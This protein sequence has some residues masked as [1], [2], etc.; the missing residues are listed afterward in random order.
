MIADGLHGLGSFLGSA[1]ALFVWP[2]VG[3]MLI[4]TLLGFAVG[5]LPGLG[6]AATM[7]LMLPLTFSMEPLAAVAF[8]LAMHAT[9][10]T[11]GDVTSVLFG[12][13]G[14]ASS[15]ATVFDGYPMTRMGQAGRAIGAVLTSSLVGAWFGAFCLALAVPLVRPLVLSFGPPEVFMLA[16]VALTTVAALSGKNM[17]KG[18]AMASLG[19]LL[20]TVGEDIATAQTR[21]TFDSLYLLDGIPVVPV[22]VGMFAVPAILASMLPARSEIGDQ[23]V[24]INSW[25]EG[26]KDTW[27]HK[28]LVLRTSLIGAYVGLIPGV[29]GTSAQFIAYGHALQSSKT[30][31]KFGKGSIEGLLAAGSVNN[32]KEGGSLLPTVAFGIPGS[33]AMAILVSAL[34]I[35]G[36]QPGPDLLTT[37]VDVTFGMVW[38]IVI[39]NLLCVGLCLLLAKRIAGLA[40]MRQT[41]LV[42]LLLV[43]ITVGSFTESFR[44]ED[45]LLMVLVGL[46]AFW[47]ERLGWPVAPMLIGLVLG[48]LAEAN[49]FLANNIYGEPSAWLT[50]PIVVILAVIAAISL[51]SPL[52]RY[53]RNRRRAR[54]D[55]TAKAR[56]FSRG[57]IF[58]AG[59]F[60]VLGAVAF[61]DVR[62]A[63]LPTSAATVPQSISF[64]LAALSVGIAVS[65]VAVLVRKRRSTDVPD[66]AGASTSAMAGDD[67]GG[68]GS[69]I[70]ALREKTAEA[71]EAE[72]VEAGPRQLAIVVAQFLAFILGLWAFGFLI[73]APIFAATYLFMVA[74]TKWWTAAIWGLLVWAFLYYI[75]WGLLSLRLWDGA[76][77]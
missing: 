17:A 48:K 52:I 47:A 38:T 13:P 62:T 8:L 31:E 33:G 43:F 23:P 39:A 71:E 76:I 4:G 9:C 16:V 40:D 28:W 56:P 19:V 15:A 26:A 65:G 75:L 44:F 5:M 14:E 58:L 35:T 7:A 50:R 27:R 51:A 49:F 70:V 61:W 67:I 77:F 12:I 59:F 20:A 57:D 37:N 18:L 74:K 64:I 1:G 73:F 66:P 54:V 45:I 42:P 68:S 69:T 36:V 72:I 24:R 41:L 10:A 25:L 53:Y 2:T 6:G 11:A 29:G 32:S 60:A 34:I 22:V 3:Y 63:D 55:A 46:L 21:L 30:P